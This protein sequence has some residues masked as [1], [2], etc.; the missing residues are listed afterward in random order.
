[1]TTTFS[2]QLV[3]AASLICCACQPVFDAS[4]AAAI[5][6]SRDPDT[7]SRNSRSDHPAFAMTREL[8]DVTRRLTNEL[9][10]CWLQAGLK[11]LEMAHYDQTGEAIP[12]SEEFTMMSALHDRFLRIIQGSRITSVNLESGGEMNE[13]RRLAVSY[14]L[15]PDKT[16]RQSRKDWGVISKQLNQLA[17]EHRK[18][19]RDAVD[20]GHSPDRVVEDAEAHFAELL[21]DHDVHPPAWFKYNG[22]RTTPAEFARSFA[23]ENYRD[24][25]MFIARAHYPTKPDKAKLFTDQDSFRTSWENIAGAIADQIDDGRSVLLTIIW[26]DRII[27]INDGVMTVDGNADHRDNT[28]HVVNISGYHTDESGRIDRIKIENT[29]GRYE[30]SSGYYVISWR[31]LK[32]IFVGVSIPDGFAYADAKGMNGDRIVE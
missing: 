21:K 30:G 14:G 1:M 29:W 6:G 4:T 19:F 13:V 23:T 27:A 16:W 10:T 15:M 28:A 32:K 18:T 2:R 12:L 9:N 24:Y 11:E 3:L 8:P 25:A 7:R 22:A 26:S 17:A 31:D 20:A 5:N